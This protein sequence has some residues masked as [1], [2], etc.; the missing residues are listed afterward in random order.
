MLLGKASFFECSFLRQQQKACHHDWILLR[1]QLGSCVVSFV[2]PSLCGGRI[3]IPSNC[4]LYQTPHADRGLKGG[5]VLLPDPSP[6]PG[7]KHLSLITLILL[8]PN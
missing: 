6:Y 1:S 3:R 5:V 8:T 2:V 7:V 4:M